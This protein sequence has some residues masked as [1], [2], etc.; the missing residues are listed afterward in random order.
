MFISGEVVCLLDEYTYQSHLKYICFQQLMCVYMY[1]DGHCTA[2][3]LL[4]PYRVL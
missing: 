2:Y 3:E 1:I 4:I